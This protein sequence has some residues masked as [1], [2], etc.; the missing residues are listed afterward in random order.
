MAFGQAKGFE[1]TVVSP[2]QFKYCSISL[3]ALILRGT[4]H[5]SIDKVIKRLKLIYDFQ[6]GEKCFEFLQPGAPLDVITINVNV[7]TCHGM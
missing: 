1:L 3:C 5:F 6:Y 4:T 7:A 2:H